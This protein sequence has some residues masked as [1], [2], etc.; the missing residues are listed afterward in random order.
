MMICGRPS[1]P[2]CPRSRRSRGAVTR[3]SPKCAALGGIIFV[4]QTGCPW[5]LLTKELGCGSGTT[6]WHRLRDWQEVGVWERLHARLLDWLGGEAATEGSR[7]SVDSM[8]V[9]A[10]RDA[11]RPGRTRSTT[12]SL[13]PS[14]TW[15]WFATASRSP[16]GSRPPTPTMRSSRSRWSTS[17]HRSPVRV[18]DRVGLAS[19]RSNSTPTS[20]TTPRRHWR[21]W[22]R[23]LIA[24][25]QS[26]APIIVD[27]PGGATCPNAA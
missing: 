19:D 15:W 10:K 20:R 12:A 22:H 7:T 16:S 18:E 6:C 14:T 8:S 25:W 17:S 13:A 26:R 27:A 21:R 24:L 9:R 4:L 23:R 11:I 5:R 2:Y 3:V 1:K